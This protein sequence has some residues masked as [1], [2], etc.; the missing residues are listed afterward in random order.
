VV[1]A[2]L[3]LACPR[4]HA[5]RQAGWKLDVPERVEFIAGVVGT[6]QLSIDVDH[7]LTVSRDAAVIVDLGSDAA[8]SIKKRRLGR[9]DAV[10]PDADSPHWSVALRSEIAGDHVVRVRVRG[11]VC[12]QKV[13]KPLD[14]RRNVAI[15]VAAA[16]PPTTNP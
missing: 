5:E 3:V 8:I 1:V 12:G 6:L 7:G 9:A 16:A 11:W 13:C 15:S 14:A 4:A 2:A 10:D